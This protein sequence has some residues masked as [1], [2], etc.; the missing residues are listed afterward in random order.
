MSATGPLGTGIKHQ[1]FT[2]SCSPTSARTVVGEHEG[3]LTGDPPEVRQHTHTG[4]GPSTV[5]ELRSSKGDRRRL[6]LSGTRGLP[7]PRTAARPRPGKLARAAANSAQERQKSEG[8]SDRGMSSGRRSET[9][10][11]RDGQ[12]RW[13]GLWCGTDTVAGDGT[14]W[15]ISAI[16]LSDVG[17][18][19]EG[20]AGG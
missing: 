2:P 8:V 11:E 5:P 18:T 20:G 14:V 16:R 12:T 17:L 3:Y 1:I 15:L 7:S 13:S 10:I 6:G 19:V 9:L 4:E